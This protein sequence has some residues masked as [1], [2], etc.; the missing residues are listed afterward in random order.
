[1]AET[2]VEEG[3][4]ERRRSSIIGTGRVS[5]ASGLDVVTVFA[6]ELSEKDS[7]AAAT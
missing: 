7:R 2:S 3:E 1:L 6:D 5:S 4:I